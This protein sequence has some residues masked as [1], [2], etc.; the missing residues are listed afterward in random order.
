MRTSVANTVARA[1]YITG[2]R[3]VSLEQQQQHWQQPHVVAFMEQSQLTDSGL[4]TSPSLLQNFTNALLGIV[5][6]SLPPA[7]ICKL[8]QNNSLP[9]VFALHTH[10]TSM[11]R[12]MLTRC[13][14]DHTVPSS[15][16]KVTAFAKL[17]RC[18]CSSAKRISNLL[19]Q[20]DAESIFVTSPCLLN[21]HVPGDDAKLLFVLYN[22]HQILLPRNKSGY[23]ANTCIQGYYSP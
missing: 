6:L 15:V 18:K 23:C 9:P 8:F 20:K 4:I 3:E 14:D 19:I 5:K 22:E 11:C 16:L 10:P 1:S 12:Q 7:I 13:L 17:V 2:Y 21:S